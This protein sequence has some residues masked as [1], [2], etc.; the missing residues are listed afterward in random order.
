[1]YYFC[2]CKSFKELF[3]LCLQPGFGRKRVQRYC[4]F[5]NRQNFF[6]KIFS[7]IPKNLQDLININP[8][9][10]LYII[11]YIKNERKS[12]FILLGESLKPMSCSRGNTNNSSRFICLFRKKV[13]TSRRFRKYQITNQRI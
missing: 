10:T 13:V 1:M 8:K 9:N 2:L 4:F 3:L 12:T 5:P 11:I 7:F 6:G